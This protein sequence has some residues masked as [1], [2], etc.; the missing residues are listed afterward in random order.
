MRRSSRDVI[1]SRP[2]SSSLLV[3]GRRLWGGPDRRTMLSGELR[4]R[5]TKQHNYRLSVR[6]SVGR[7]VATHR[8]GGSALLFH[9]DATTSICDVFRCVLVRSWRSAMINWLIT[10]RYVGH[11]P[12]VH[13]ILL[14]R[15]TLHYS[16]SVESQH[17][18][19]SKR[20]EW[21]PKCGNWSF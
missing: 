1:M 9:G 5:S 14:N 2:N 17:N 4:P 15:I 3:G 7:C 21:G 20:I 16:V 6:P 8:R 10:L 13:T 18:V 12:R 11:V 19:Q